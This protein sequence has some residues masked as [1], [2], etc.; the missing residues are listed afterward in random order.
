MS[1][2]WEQGLSLSTPTIGGSLEAHMWWARSNIVAQP[3]TRKIWLRPNI[4][5]L[6]E[7]NAYPTESSASMQ[8]HRRSTNQAVVLVSSTLLAETRRLQQTSEAV[9]LEPKNPLIIHLFYWRI[10][11]KFRPEKCDFH[12]YKWF[13]MAK[14]GPNSP[15]FEKKKNSNR[16]LSAISSNR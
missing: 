8:Q 9:S 3:A 12:Q 6:L 5:Q 13:F 11:A 4:V 14:N 10:F 1:P 2:I 15:I 16:Q 7:E